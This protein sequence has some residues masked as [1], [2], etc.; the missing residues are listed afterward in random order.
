MATFTGKQL[1]QS[2]CFTK[3]AGLR[4]E[5]FF[6]TPIFREH[7]RRLFW[8]MF[9]TEAATRSVLWRKMFL[10]I[11]QNSQENNCA[12]VS[13]LI[14]LQ[15]WGCWPEVCNFIENRL[16]YWCFPANFANFLRT[17]FLQ[18]NSTR[19]LQF[20]STLSA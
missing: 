20:H 10:E 17:P 14:R 12:S 1:C 6:R 11:S 2:L 13:F 3:V 4:S 7:L 9:L 8:P 15:T 19:L 5:R 16:W 18:N